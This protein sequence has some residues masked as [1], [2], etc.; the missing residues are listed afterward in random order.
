MANPN[1]VNVANI[2]GKTAVLNVTTTPTNIVIN[3][4]SSGTV[5]K[6]NNLIISNINGTNPADISASFFRGGVEYKVAH[7]IVVPADATLVVLD[8]GTSL[9][10]EEGDAIRITGS[11]NS[12]LQAVCS[13]EVI[14]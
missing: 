8:K 2:L 7:T 6:I 5:F 9:Y 11:A 13:Y 1:I 10:L 3:E 12:V 4:S 14:S